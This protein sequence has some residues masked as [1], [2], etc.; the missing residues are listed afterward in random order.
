MNTN[1]P[2]FWSLVTPPPPR[3][4]WVWSTPSSDISANISTHLE[5]VSSPMH[6]SMG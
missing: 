3:F 2:K 6:L 5:K 4:H 1:F